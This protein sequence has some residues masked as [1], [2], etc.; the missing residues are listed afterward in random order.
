MSNKI[1][2]INDGSKD[3]TLEILQNLQKNNSKISVINNKNSGAES[4]LSLL[5]TIMQLKRG[6]ILPVVMPGEAQLPEDFE[7]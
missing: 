6:M 4:G 1:I 7:I 5:D 3:N 2:V